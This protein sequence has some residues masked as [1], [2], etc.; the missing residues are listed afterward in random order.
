LLLAQDGDLNINHYSYMISKVS[1]ML[2]PYGM[3]TAL[4]YALHSFEL[5]AVTT[6]LNRSDTDITAGQHQAAY[7][8][9]L[10][11][12]DTLLRILNT[13]ADPA[14]LLSMPLSNE[15]KVELANKSGGTDS[16]AYWSRLIQQNIDTLQKIKNHAQH[17]DFV[18][19]M[20]EK[21]AQ[22]PF[23]YKWHLALLIEN[24]LPLKATVSKITKIIAVL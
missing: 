8:A 12:D 14:L 15:R 11:G 5:D 10:A 24:G 13:Y 21:Y 20:L 23:E 17:P 18:Q 19:Q 22:E 4:S 9:V 3:Q 2:I 16:E 1:S 6:I 7:N